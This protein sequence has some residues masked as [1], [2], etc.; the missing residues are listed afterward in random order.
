V[1][2]WRTRVARSAAGGPVGDQA[3]DG[4][5]RPSVGL[6]ASEV[7]LQGPPLL[8]LG[9]GMLHTDPLGRLPFAGLPVGGH[10]LGWG[11]LGRWERRGADPIGNTLARPR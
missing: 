1:F 6:A 11:G 8:V 7:A 10:L 4:Q 2:A 3:G 9:D 5:I